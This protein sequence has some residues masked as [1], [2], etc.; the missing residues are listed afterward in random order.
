M[1]DKFALDQSNDGT[2]RSAR[3]KVPGC[4]NNNLQN[5]A[6]IAVEIEGDKLT[7]V[8]FGDI[9]SRVPTHEIDLTGALEKFRKRTE[10][11]EERVLDAV[12]VG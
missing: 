1:S 4:G 5:G 11:V 2:V 3:M 12:P 6:V 10:V 7:L 8:V 9:N